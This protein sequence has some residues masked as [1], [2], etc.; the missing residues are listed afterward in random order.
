VAF[1]TPVGDLYSISFPD[2]MS[3]GFTYDEFQATLHESLDEL[4]AEGRWGAY[5][6]RYKLVALVGGK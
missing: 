3:G 1:G 5:P 4:V 2:Q 6:D